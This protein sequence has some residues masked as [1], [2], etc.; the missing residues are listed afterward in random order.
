MGAKVIE[1]HRHYQFRRV[2]ASSEQQ[3]GDAGN[4]L[5]LD[6]FENLGIITLKT[7]K[8]KI[9]CQVLSL[10]NLSLLCPLII[11]LFIITFIF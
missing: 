5:L 4:L 9:I 7:F 8:R 2:N 6:D 11:T 3:I 1:K 10:I